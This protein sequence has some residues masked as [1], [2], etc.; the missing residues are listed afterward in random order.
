MYNNNDGGWQSGVDF[1]GLTAGSGYNIL[2]KDMNGCI[3]SAAAGCDELLQ[4]R[5]DPQQ[6]I[7]NQKKTSEQKKVVQEIST[8]IETEKRFSIKTYPNPF[9]NEVNLALTVN[10]PGTGIVEIYDIMGVKVKTVYQGSFKEG[11]HQYRIQLPAGNNQYIYIVR[12]EGEKLSGNLLR[13]SE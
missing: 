13:I 11:I 12:I 2:V 7:M 10:K 8:I 1:A 3:S 6:N 5:K 9:R 4:R